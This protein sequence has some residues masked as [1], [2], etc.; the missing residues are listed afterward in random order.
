MASKK[1]SFE[2]YGYRTNSRFG[3]W[4][5]VVVQDGMVSVTGPRIG[6]LPYRLWIGLQVVLFWLIP[7][8]VLAAVVL[9]DWRYLL[10]ALALFI[11]HW[12]VGG[13][14]ATAMWEY[15]NVLAIGPGHPTYSFP[16]SGVKRARIGR[17]WAR[18]GLWLV[19]P[20][21]VWMFD[22]TGAAGQ[23]VSF[24]A[25]AGDTSGDAVYAFHLHA[26]D[27]AQALVR[28]LEGE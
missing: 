7:A 1:E 20:Y 27:D 19:I 4:T 2:G 12:G 26:E 8:A 5:K 15:A 17:A 21:V 10:L 23:V 6:V 22:I 3:S 28:L 16:L 11:V 24:E 18:K 14:G 25:P 9:R 13:I